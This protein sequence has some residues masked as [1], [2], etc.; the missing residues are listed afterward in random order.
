MK[1]PRAA[2]ALPLAAML[3]CS[4]RY[5][6]DKDASA[7]DGADDSSNVIDGAGTDSAS[8]SMDPMPCDGGCTLTPN[9]YCTS[10]GLQQSSGPHCCGGGA[11]GLV[12]HYAPVG[13]HIVDCTA[14]WT[15]T[16]QEA[17]CLCKA[18]GTL[19][20][21]ETTTFADAVCGHDSQ[22][23]VCNCW[24]YGVSNKCS[25][26]TRADGNPCAHPSG[27]CPGSNCWL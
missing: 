1:L 7:S 25:F 27:T 3:A 23:I 14:N 15:C 6:G 9:L 10:M 18:D 21:C 22:N 13:P 5:P 11:C 2:S 20:T 8:S 17:M 12:E 24:G 16:L 19:S 4:N 26:S